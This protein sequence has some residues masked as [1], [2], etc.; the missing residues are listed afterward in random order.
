LSC[1][2][3]VAVVRLAAVPWKA[4]RFDR[5]LED[6]LDSLGL[7]KA[8]K[9]ETGIPDPESVDGTESLS[10]YP[11]SGYDED[12]V[13]PLRNSPIVSEGLAQA[14]PSKS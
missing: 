9:F 5:Y 11:D 7:E 6:G 10:D 3:R 8:K 2:Q 12:Y 13:P 14:K 4:L 1:G